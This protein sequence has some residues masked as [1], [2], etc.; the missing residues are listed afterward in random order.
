MAG[1]DVVNDA[2]LDVPGKRPGGIGIAVSA[3]GVTVQWQDALALFDGYDPEVLMVSALDGN[4]RVAC[5]DRFVLPS[6]NSSDA[7]TIAAQERRLLQTLLNSRERVAGAGGMVRVDGGEGIGHELMDLAALD[8][9]VAEVRARIVWY[10]T[11]A[12]GNALPRAEYW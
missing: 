11:A 9:R 4:G 12:G 3:A 2:A 7:A 1:W 5:I 8:R 10:E 6:P